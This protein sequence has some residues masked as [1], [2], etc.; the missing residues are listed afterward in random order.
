MILFS[1]VCDHRNKASEVWSVIW[2]AYITLSGRAN[3]VNLSKLQ[4]HIL[5]IARSLKLP[6]VHHL[7]PLKIIYNTLVTQREV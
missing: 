7:I 2:K 3:T 4:K 5:V 6:I 1:F